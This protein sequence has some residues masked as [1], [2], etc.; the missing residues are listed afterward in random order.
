MQ[1]AGNPGS[2]EPK[3]LATK[4]A[5]F[6]KGR[7][8]KGCYGN[9]IAPVGQTSTQAPQSAQVLSSTFAFPSTISIAPVGQACL[10]SPHP[11]HFVVSTTA[12][13]LVQPPLSTRPSYLQKPLNP[14]IGGGWARS[15]FQEQDN[16]TPPGEDFDPSIKRSNLQTTADLL[17]L[18]LPRE[19]QFRQT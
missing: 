19:R 13:I 7:K 12:G 3:K 1:T 8:R 16:P 17:Q 14:V 9:E 15:S 10:Q 5:R 6:P 11:L 2:T 18:I 4:F